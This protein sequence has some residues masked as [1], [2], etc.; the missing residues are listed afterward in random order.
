MVR[1][2]RQDSP[3]A[4]MDFPKLYT[5]SSHAPDAI[6]HIIVRKEAQL[7]RLPLFSSNKADLDE[8]TWV[9]HRKGSI[10]AA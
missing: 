6:Y 1:G 2:V 10:Y 8:L 5:R 7:S 3:R 9:K 4:E